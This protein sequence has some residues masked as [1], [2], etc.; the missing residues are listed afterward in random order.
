MVVPCQTG[1]PSPEAAYEAFMVILT[2]LES[3]I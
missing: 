1:D 3:L 2:L